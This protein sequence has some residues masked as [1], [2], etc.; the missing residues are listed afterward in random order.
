M[1]LIS[2]YTCKL[3]R[4]LTA[5]SLMLSAAGCVNEDDNCPVPGSGSD[6]V[7]LRFTIV[8]RTPMNSSRQSSRAADISGD[9]IGTPAENYLNLA[10]RDI[11]FLLF[12]S[13]QKLL[14]NFTPDVDITPVDGSNYITYTVRATISEPYFANVDNADTDFYI[15]V[16]ANGRPYGLSAFALAPGVTSISDVAGQLASFTMPTVSIDPENYGRFGWQ[17]D[18]PGIADGKYI[19]MAGLQHFKIAKGAF[20]AAG[21]ENFVE[22]SPGDGSKDINMLRA[23][24]KIEVIDRIDLADGVQFPG[25]ESRMSIEKVELMGYCATGT[26][27]PSYDQWNRNDVLET[28]QVIAPTLA[29]P[30]V[31]RNPEPASKDNVPNYDVNTGIEFH[32]DASYPSDDEHYP[33]SNVFSVYVPEYSLASIGSNNPTYAVVTVQTAPNDSRR[34]LMPLATYNNGAAG[35]NISSLLRNHIY[36][37]AITGFAGP[38]TDLDLI[39]RNWDDNE[40]IWDYTDN[41]GLA[42]GGAIAFDTNTCTV[43]KSA[44]E[45][46][47][48]NDRADIK[49]SFKLASPVNATWRAVFV[50]ESGTQGAFVFVDENGNEVESVSGTINGNTAANLTIRT[51]DNPRENNNVE[52]LQIIVTMA[53]GRSVT[54]DVLAGGG[55]GSGK[56]Y[57]TVIQNHQL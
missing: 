19:P 49:A 43:D 34:F 25:I 27:L 3:V 50:H 33:G 45:V 54:A 2:K 20:D 32:E 53:D 16:V 17:P 23:V 41:P 18:Q 12:D 10:A 48:R 38:N 55:Y 56:T 57:I 5:F 6:T 52:R 24:A 51:K 29:D 14:R 21:P 37:Y 15:M 39:V 26:I 7:K 44:A 4:L 31:Y 46:V 42:E 40:V 47:F 13:D 9:K 8:T 11:S 35:D 28:Q 30:L 36:Q 22:L 1:K